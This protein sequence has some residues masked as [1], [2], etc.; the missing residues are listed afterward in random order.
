MHTPPTPL[1]KK[2]PMIFINTAEYG[3]QKVDKCNKNKYA[4]SKMKFVGSIHPYR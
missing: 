3:L 4:I 1:H 2:G